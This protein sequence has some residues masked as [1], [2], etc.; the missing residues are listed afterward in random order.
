MKMGLFPGELK[1]FRQMPGML[2]FLLNPLP[3]S[4]QIQTMAFPVKLEMPFY[5]GGWQTL[6]K[7]C[8]R[9]KT[10]LSR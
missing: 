6:D 7:F 10:R 3:K 1:S 2:T 8:V 9:S 4:F 5:L